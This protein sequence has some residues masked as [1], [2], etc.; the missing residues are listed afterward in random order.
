MINHANSKEP[1]KSQKAQSPHIWEKMIINIGQIIGIIAFL[2]VWMFDSFV[3]HFSD[4][5]SKYVPWWILIIIAIPIWTLAV[6]LRLSGMKAVF[7]SRSKKPILIT[8]G[9]FKITRHP[10]YLSL[11]LVYMGLIISTLSLISLIVFFISFLYYNFVANHEEKYLLET[12]GDKYEEYQRLV[13]KWG[14]KIINR[15]NE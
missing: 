6:Y 3:F 12:F 5:L 9:A 11:L 10:N 15:I 2:I 14:I 4:F 7:G 13:P 1:D 8:K